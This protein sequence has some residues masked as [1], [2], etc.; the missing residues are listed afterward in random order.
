[1]CDFRFALKNLIKSGSSSGDQASKQLWNKLLQ[2]EGLAH[3]G[4]GRSKSGGWCPTFKFKKG[5]SENQEYPRQPLWIIC[6]VGD[7]DHGWRQRKCH[8]TSNRQWSSGLLESQ[9]LQLNWN[10]S[11]RLLHQ[12]LHTALP[13]SNSHIGGKVLCLSYFIF[14]VMNR[15]QNNIRG[16]IQNSQS[17]LCSLK[18]GDLK[19]TRWREKWLMQ[20][21]RYQ[22]KHQKCRMC[23]RVPY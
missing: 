9:L 4:D 15:W 3:W 5:S 23:L 19:E 7:L 12:H 6:E 8:V 22:V 13:I 20:Q 18:F 14:T 16:N 17:V 21:S 2:L 10:G 11:G 1:M